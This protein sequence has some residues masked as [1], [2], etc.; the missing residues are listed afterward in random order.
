MRHL[1]IVC[2]FSLP[3]VINANNYYPN[4]HRKSLYG[5]NDALF[6][7][8]TFN[9]FLDD[10]PYETS[11]Q[12][13]RN[14]RA[15]GT[16]HDNQTVLVDTK[17]NS[18]N[19]SHKQLMVRWVGEGSKVIICLA[20]D[21]LISLYETKTPNPSAVFISYDDGDTYENKTDQFKLPNGSYAVLDKFY[22]HPKYNS[23]FVFTD[24]IHNMLYITTNHGKSIMGTQ[25][26]FTPSELS[27][28]EMQPHIIVA[29]DKN[30]TLN[31][32]WITEDFG[33]TFRSAHEFVKAFYMF[34]DGDVNK[35][36]VHRNEPNGLGSIVH[37]SNLFRNRMSEVYA[38]N[39][40]DF[41]IKN[42]YFFTTRNN[43]KGGLDLYVSFKLGKQL[44]CIFDTTLPILNF[45]IADVTGPRALVVVNHSPVSSH[46]Y[47]SDNLNGKDGKVSFTL[48]LE[49]VFAFF[50][51][52]T[53][54]GTL[55]SHTAEEAFADLYKV[56]GLSGIYIASKLISKPTGNSLGPQNLASL[57]TFDHGASWRKIQPPTVDVEFQ[58]TGCLIT[59]NCSLHLSQ[60]FSQLYPESRS[61]PILSSKSAPGTII[62]TGVLGHNLKGHSGVYISVDAGLTWKQTLRE[63]YYFNMGDHGGILSAVKLFKVKR[64]T[65]HILYSIDEG[66]N[67]DQIQFNN[68][69]IRLYGLMTEP[70]E[71]TTVFTMFGSLPKEHRWIIMKIDFAKVFPAKC[72]DKD[73]K[74]WSPSFA[75]E[76]RSYIPCLMGEQI[77]YQRRL[78]HSRCLNG[79]DY[80]RVISKTQCDCD[81]N[82]FE[83]DFG[84]KKIPG[85]FSRCVRDANLTTYDPYRRPDSCPHG[86]FY[87]RTKGY[88][89]ISGD[90]CIDGF[91]QHYLPDSVPCPFK[92]VSDFLLFAQRDNIS[93]FDLV[94]RKLEVLPLKTLKN[95]IAIDFDFENN[96]VYWAD[97]NLDT[98]NRQCLNNGSKM[99]TLVSKDLVSIEGMAYDWISKTLYF[100]D[101][102]RSKIELIRTDI[103]HSG[104]MRKTILDE[105]VLKKPRGIAI[106][107]QAG[108]LYWTDWS[109]ENPSVNRAN[110]NGL[111]SKA[112]FGKDKVEWPNGITVDYIANRIYWV[113][114]RRDYIGSSDLHGDD[115]V[116]VVH[117]SNVVAHPFAVAVFKNNIYWDDWKKNAIFT[118]DKDLYKGIDVVVSDL[119]G[120]MDL[121]VYANGLQIGKNGCANANCSHI[122]VGL[123]KNG[124]ACLCP[125]GMIA[126]KDGMSCLCPG[127][128]PPMPN[129]TC[130]TV[131]SSCSSNHFSCGNGLCVPNGWKCDGENDCGDNS[132]EMRCGTAP[133]PVTFHM[134][135]DGK[136]LPHYWRCDFDMDCA[137]GSD[138]IN[139]PKQNCTES[140][141][142]C[143]NGRCISKN[144]RC[145]GENDCRDNS[146]E[147][148]CDPDRPAECKGEDEFQCISGAV[149]CIPNT[150]KC[151]DEPDCRDGSDEVNCSNNIC[152]EVQFSCGPPTNRCIFK[153]WVCD[154]DLDCADGRDEANC[155]ATVKPDQS[156]PNIDAFASKNRSC[157]DWMF[158]C[159]ND[160]CIPTWWK[161]D[162]VDDCGD[163]SDEVNCSKVTR[164][165]VPTTTPPMP[166][167]KPDN[168]VCGNN[169]FR[170]QK[171]HCIL[172]SW[173]CD[174]SYDCPDGEDEQD[175]E[176]ITS[177]SRDQFKC[178]QDGSCIPRSKVCNGVPDCP[179]MTDEAYCRDQYLPNEPATPSCSVGFF[180]C[181]E[182]SC[183]PLSVLCDGKRDCLDGYDEK[184]CSTRQRVYQVMQMK[185]D[186]QGSSD[187]SSLL[188]YWAI[189]ITDKTP[190]KL[191]Y[192]PSIS[193]SGENK[194]RNESWTEKTEY[195]FTNLQPYTFYNMTIYVREKSKMI[196]F[197]PAKYYIAHTLEGVPSPPVNVQAKQLNGSQIMITW[198]QPIKPNGIIKNYKI[199]WSAE[200]VSPILLFLQGNWTSHILSG[201]FLHGVTYTFYIIA[202]NARYQSNRSESAKLV[203]D[204]ATV[205]HKVE[206]VKFIEKNTTVEMSW[207]YKGDVDGFA[208][209]VTTYTLIYPKLPSLTTTDRNITL[210][211]AP[212]LTYSIQIFAYRNGLEGPRSHYQVSTHG[213]RLPVIDIVQIMTLKD[214]GTTVKLSWQRPEK[215]GKVVWEYG[216]YYGLLISTLFEPAKYQTT[217][218]SATITN[219]MACETYYFAVGLVGPYGIGPLPHTHTQAVTTLSNP[220]APPKNVRVQADEND[221]LKMVI[222]W[223]PSCGDKSTNTSYII[224]I[225]EKATKRNWM[226]KVNNKLSHTLAV[227]TGGIY[228]ITVF[229]NV[230]SATVSE[231]VVYEA[232]P[233]YPPMELQVYPEWNGSF[234]VH[235]REQDVKL[236]SP[237]S[238]E[239]LVQEGATLNETTAQKFLVDRPPFMYTNDSAS[240]YTF[241]VRIKT[242][243]GFR[244]ILS[245]TQ[246]KVARNLNE[247]KTSSFN[248][249][250]ILVPTLF[251]LISLICIIAFLVIR[252]RRLHNSFV[253]FANSHYNSRSGAAT[254]DDN[255]LEEEDS[256]RIVGFSDD[257]PLVVA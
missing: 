141:F 63:L 42:D 68:E 90:N 4:G 174:G 188:L 119:P 180:P 8:Q 58:D 9:F 109:A 160:R 219:L 150:W 83:C 178:S 11:D 6:E 64:E 238:Y 29:L 172:S 36:L 145:D 253:R 153:T 22:N 89:K 33:Q 228:S 118:S 112:L 192:L 103:N 14:R 208:I 232:P 20:R 114:A 79:L 113:E 220:K 101:G 213:N 201:D 95:V 138:E 121:K 94:S 233:I 243:K 164:P 198:D 242:K 115:F 154:G 204:G 143:D 84:F 229:T 26:K 74:M 203:F 130:S 227:E 246:S 49:D 71:N 56:E 57:I 41:F 148:N 230:P 27:F 142:Q 120:L 65:R 54:Q 98:I 53:W 50:P 217:N 193:K 248:L 175:C 245:K 62:A 161:C 185:T 75:D 206:N 189:S 183:Y 73:Y 254:F 140:Q 93:R 223:Q 86:H 136:C 177:C 13:G 51:N 252:N 237:F 137:D 158:K 24:I 157:Q 38:T 195:L 176:G 47:V 155:T 39:I 1:I 21:S 256:P 222:S 25:L 76:N 159:G 200:D 44:P 107:P 28:D 186:I 215:V 211:L 10:D 124:Y 226:I 165:V 191:E 85:Q 97:I 12:S 46:L 32:L 126:A 131:G 133:C 31:R 69:D 59:K 55:L 199:I 61:I 111:S 128:A 218:L 163:G 235:W 169:Q 45:F 92:K 99:E 162:E 17:I 52:K 34:K 106:H 146:D 239:V 182:G 212:G 116:E 15:S 249:T 91:E 152:S 132:D 184:D 181:D 216:V 173:L 190:V 37:S 23:Y 77:T 87:M 231:P 156:K 257:E 224:S 151:D 35:V 168:V 88:R 110:L 179:D 207:N 40:Q 197:P 194:W 7:G 202:S 236:N 67:W 196:V 3:Y 147:R 82:D 72:E 135:S 170:C 43:S 240:T 117:G 134:C 18:L 209:N 187:E 241:A 70:G 125:D 102:T 96:C 129:G 108:Y 100:V 251:S 66:E 244:S 234:F 139:C 122:C 2:L 78:R 127:G 123:P 104:R 171:G 149:T 210:T 16:E 166:P 19:D 80:V 214:V 250:A 30:D 81:A 48:S 221:R 255:A 247:P 144:W 225:T 205:V 5:A 105:T 167:K 60:K